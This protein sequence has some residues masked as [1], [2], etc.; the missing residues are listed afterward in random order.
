MSF[1][2]CYTSTLSSIH[3]IF[4]LAYLST[5]LS[6]SL[7]FHFVIWSL[8]TFIKLKKKNLGLSI[9]ILPN[10]IEMNVSALCLMKLKMMLDPPVFTIKALEA[11]MINLLTWLSPFISLQS[12]LPP[13]RVFGAARLGLSWWVEDWTFQNQWIWAWSKIMSSS[14]QSTPLTQ[15]SQNFSQTW[16]P[17]SLSHPSLPTLKLKE[18]FWMYGRVHV[19][20]WC[21]SHF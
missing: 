6:L 19:Y 9:T 21:Q 4:R 11:E 18:G 1:I 13:L 2:Y 12:P 15:S 17:I 5:S 14:P 8:A 10:L 20:F 3:W 7:S 16:E